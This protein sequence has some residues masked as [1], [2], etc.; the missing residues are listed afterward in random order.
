[1]AVKIPTK[2]YVDNQLLEKLNFIKLTEQNM[3][4]N[5]PDTHEMGKYSIGMFIGSEGAAYIGFYV[6]W[7]VFQIKVNTGENTK[8][9]FKYGGFPWTDWYSLF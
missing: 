9:R 6:S 7:I 2:E 8:C 4:E 1:M 3:N 5:Y